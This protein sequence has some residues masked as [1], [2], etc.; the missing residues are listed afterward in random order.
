[1]NHI[2]VLHPL[3][4]YTESFERFYITGIR[5]VYGVKNRYDVEIQTLLFNAD[6]FTADQARAWIDKR[7]MAVI[8]FIPANEEIIN[9]VPKRTRGKNSP[10]S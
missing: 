2:A 4:D 6:K 10:S 5:A 1:M 7:K 3:S 9:A 8:E